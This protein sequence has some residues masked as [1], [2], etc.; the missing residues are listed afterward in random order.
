MESESRHDWSAHTV[1]E[2]DD[3]KDYIF[4]ADDY[5][6][7]KLRVKSYC[8]EIGGRNIDSESFIEYI[9][10]Q[11]PNFIL[12]QKEI[13]R[14]KWG[15]KEAIRETRSSED[16]LTD[17]LY[18]EILLFLFVEGMLDLP[19]ISYKVSLKPDRGGEVSGADSVYFGNYRGQPALGLGEA[20][21]RQ[22]WSDCVSSSLDSTDRF[23]GPSAEAKRKAEINIA[24][25]SAHNNF[26]NESADELVE[27]VTST[28]RE[29]Q[30]IHPIFLGYQ[31]D[32]IGKVQEEPRDDGELK[33]KI[34]EEIDASNLAED[35]EESLD[36]SYNDLKRYWL[37]FFLLPVENSN[38]FKK[39]LHNAIFIDD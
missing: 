23:H 6:E 12:S 18:G 21:F 36:Q 19:M 38:R 9:S 22:S 8:I 11:F 7:K 5:S 33:E 29:Y 31:S 35:I 25:R 16:V 17:G 37:L 27:A 30:I 20:K 2:E 3:L 34:L 14:A 10:N 15:Y 28:P 26:K 39:R 1:I 24:A 32:K 13:D 4:E